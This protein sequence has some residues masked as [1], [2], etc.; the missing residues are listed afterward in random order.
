VKNASVIGWPIKHS[1]SPLIHGHWLQ[2]AGIVGTYTKTAVAPEQL[3]DFIRNLSGAGLAGCNVT[4][5]HK[6]AV[7]PLLDEVDDAAVA[8]GAV[9][10]VWLQGSK[11]CGS[12]TDAEGFLK[13]LNATAPN[14]STQ[15]RPAIILGAGGA[16]RAAIFA[17]LGAGVDRIYLANR[18]PR[19]AEQ[20]ANAFGNRVTPV[21]FS[22]LSRIAGEAGLLVNTTTLGMQ[23]APALDFDTSM[24]PPICVVYDIVYVP[25][26][27]P[28]LASARARELRVVDGLGM[29]LHQAAPGF[30]K[31]FG[32]RPEV[33][34]ELRDLVVADLAGLT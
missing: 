21:S 8:I 34:S 16:A 24:L 13:H 10:T 1:R 3:P 19:N 7:L 27:T 12:N 32:I 31:W 9:N 29:L 14:W 11:L 17:L 33:T 20:L 26:E 4:V 18:T 5:P 30:E 6:Q 2:K 22:D 25:L 28:L 15:L 23:G